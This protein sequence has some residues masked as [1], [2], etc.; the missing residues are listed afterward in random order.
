MLCSTGELR[1]RLTLLFGLLLGCS[2]ELTGGPR[3]DA[4]ATVLSECADT[5]CD[6]GNACTLDR[7]AADGSCEHEVV[8][9]D[10]GDACTLDRCTEVGTCEHVTLSCDDGDPCTTD[11][12]NARTGCQHTAVICDEDDPCQSYCDSAAGGCR[13][14]RAPV[15]TVCA[16][17]D[18]PCQ[19]A[20]TC[21]SEGHCVDN[22]LQPSGAICRAAQGECDLADTCDDSGECVDRGHAPQ[23]GLCGD[24]T[25]TPCD[26]RDTCDGQGNCLPNLAAAGSLCGDTLE[27]TCSAADT[28]DGRGNC[29][30]NHA[31]TGTSCDDCDSGHCEGCRQGICVDA[32]ADCGV[33]NIAP[34]AAFG[35]SQRL[36]DSDCSLQAGASVEGYQ[37]STYATGFTKPVQVTFAP[38]DPAGDCLYV[39]Q[40]DGR[41]YRMS[42]NDPDSR[43]VF[44]TVTG[45]QYSGSATSG[46]GLHSIAFH[47]NYPDQPYVYAAFLGSGSVG[48][49]ARFT[50]GEP[51]QSCNAAVANPSEQ[52]ELL[53]IWQR[54]SNHNVNQVVF[55]ADGLLYVAVGDGGGSNDSP[56]QN[57]ERDNSLN[58]KILRIDVDRAT[59]Y[60]IPAG[61][62]NSESGSVACGTRACDNG[63]C[64]APCR[65]VFA[66]GLR[67]PWRLSVD[68][69]T[70]DLYT[71]D[72]GQNA[73][74]EVNLIRA[75]GDYGWN[76]AE[77]DDSSFERPLVAYPIGSEG[78]S[79]TGGVVYRPTG[80]AR[81][82]SLVGHYLFADFVSNRVW[83]LRKDQ[84]TGVGSP[85]AGSMRGTHADPSHLRFILSANPG[86]IAGMGVDGN[87]ELYL[88][89]FGGTI[90]QLAETHAGSGPPETLSDTGC[91]EEPRSQRLAPAFIPYEVN[92]PL[93]TDGAQKRRYILLPGSDSK[94]TLPQ[95]AS[96]SEEAAH[97]T[98]TFPTG[99]ILVK[100]FWQAFGNPPQPKPLETRFL[101]KRGTSRWDGYSYRWL[102]DGSDAELLE[103]ESR[104]Q[105]YDADGRRSDGAC[106]YTHYFPSRGD[107][108]SC[109]R[110]EVGVVLGL[111]TAQLNRLHDYDGVIDNQLRAMNNIGL[112]SPP[113]LAPGQDY[114][115]M[116]DPRDSDRCP[117]PDK[118]ARAYLAANCAQCHNGGGGT[119][120]DLSFLASLPATQSCDQP[121][122]AGDLGVAD[123]RI[124]APGAPERS[125]LYLRALRRGEGQMPP[126][127]SLRA[128]DDGT[129]LIREWIEDL[130]D[131][132]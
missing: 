128:D 35:L 115:A 125:L 19:L 97:Q 18:K 91:Y 25:D 83:A 65:E 92:S 86:S 45:L 114:P 70:G 62:M 69:A 31:A 32:E 37:L 78:R 49:V 47:P 99:T 113:L 126:I 2:A 118:R 6:D 28:C 8:S 48:R 80:D 51:G 121:P 42:R 53:S 93:W 54:N 76:N 14:G 22:G 101:V 90:T 63:Q 39:V 66:K 95:G 56:Q 17:V 52:L 21:D 24:A 60:A 23:G 81:A 34:S 44:M 59:P 55:G 108:G 46:H 105:C 15:G 68:P 107:C 127:G 41:V 57:A 50:I 106:A 110:Q 36:V 72:V 16:D 75:G 38:N 58:G 40:L 13:S 73:W 9:C 102:D 43:R 103:D 116:P 117:D 88:A 26:A 12:C 4:Q 98:W 111:R 71:G 64:A 61:N 130:P 85:A 123:A 124:V 67:N 27:S 20:D 79:I 120:M 7:C 1:A 119:A 30:L 29:L 82:P 33:D 77:G 100:E 132:R 3:P 94:I 87:G 5:D 89:H 122:S 84:Q 129:A 74:E 131:C 109:H 10:D 11:S 96:T 112:F 104:Q